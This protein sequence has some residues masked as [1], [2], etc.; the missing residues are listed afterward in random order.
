MLKKWEE[1]PAKFHNDEVRKYYRILEKKKCS[2]A[3]KRVFDVVLATLMT[4][5]LS[6]VMLILAVLIKREDGGSVFYRQER[7]TAY[8]KSF[9][10]FKFRTMVEH[11]DRQGP[12][13]TGKRDS[14]ITVIGE[15]L[16]KCRLDELPQLLNVITGDMSFVGTRPEVQKYVDAYSG[17]M[18]ATLLLPAGI[19]SP[20]SIAY[21]D[22]DE[23]MARYTEEGAST[24]E[25]YIQHVL[26]EKMKYNLKYLRT[27]SVLNDWKIMI[28]TVVA[29]LK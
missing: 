18:L 7:V 3:I 13:V 25:A 9:R 19:T 17:E 8:G 16:R 27:F 24:D 6:P 29:V 10:I 15:K 22:E 26:P 12:L 5:I 11:A 21:K 23:I 28:Q 2:L 14:R 4:I 20:A 1:L